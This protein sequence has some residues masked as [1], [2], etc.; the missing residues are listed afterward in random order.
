MRQ[1]SHLCRRCTLLFV[2]QSAAD[3]FLGVTNV[4]VRPIGRRP[5]A[6]H[7]GP[8]ARDPP[9]TSHPAD[10]LG[11][12]PTSPST[13]ATGLAASASCGARST[14]SGRCATP[15][16]TTASATPTCSADPGARARRRRRASSPRCSTASARST[17]SRAASARRASPSRPAPASTSTSWTRRP[18][19]ASTPC[20]T[21][22]SG[23]CSA[24]PAGAQGVHPRRGPHALQGGG[25][26]PAQDARGAA[27][28]RRVR[29]GHHRSAEGQPHDPQPHPAPRVPPPAHGGARARTSAA[30]RPTPGSTSTDE[31]STRSC[32]QGGGSA[33]DTLSALDQVVAAGGV[34]PRSEPLDELVEALIDADTA[35]R[36]PPS[37]APSRPAATRAAH[38]AARRP[39]ARR[40][41]VADGTR[42]RAPARP[43]GATWR[44]PGQAPRR[45]RPPCGPWRSSA[46]RWSTSATHPTPGCCSTSPSCGSPTRT[47]TR[48]RPRCSPASSGSSGPSRRS[49][50]PTG[51]AAA[52]VLRR[53]PR[54]HQARR[55]PSPDRPRAS[56]APRPPPPLPLPAHRR[57]AGQ[58]R[59]RRHRGAGRRRSPW[60]RPP[61][62]TGARRGGRPGRALRPHRRRR[63]QPRRADPGL[64]RPGRAPASI[65]PA[66]AFRP[67]ATDRR[68][69][70]ARRSRCPT[71]PTAPAASSTGASS[72]PRA[73]RPTSAGPSGSASCSSHRRRRGPGGAAERGAPRAPPDPEP[74]EEAS[75]RPSWSTPGR[76]LDLAPAVERVTQAFPGAELMARADGPPTPRRCR[77]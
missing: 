13:A 52:R 72:R 33:R 36:W 20:A 74:V 30:S 50:A 34:R 58:G 5:A 11:P 19:T 9:T 4:T 43:A 7:S 44:R 27:R 31:R 3:Q 15:C 57:G 65:A 73:R 25:G 51:P 37:P 49:G 71:S 68:P 32:R 45:R 54:R 40:L 75:I 6:A 39:A 8:P 28:P 67:P 42:P 23:R 21:S 46:R 63:P 70:V 24:R 16:G 61:S 47:P 60:H 26:R 2:T 69:T 56:P 59:Q 55:W 53:G 38:R 22:S 77:R 35:G 10:R 17:A 64:G 41:P 76:S 1:E 18:T 29:A 48:R 14:S 12:W 62:A 66:K